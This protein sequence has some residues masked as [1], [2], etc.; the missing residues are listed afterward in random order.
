[1]SWNVKE[2]G[3]NSPHLS[4]QGRYSSLLRNSNAPMIEAPMNVT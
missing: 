3:T 1:M 4:P 2:D